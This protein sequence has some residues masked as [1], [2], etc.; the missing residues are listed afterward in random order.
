M[1]LWTTATCNQYLLANLIKILSSDIISEKITEKYVEMDD[2]YKEYSK[3]ISK[4]NLIL[5]CINSRLT[6][7][8][9]PKSLQ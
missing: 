8:Y 9:S 2:L 4:K 6:Q 3:D 5:N 7:N 1:K